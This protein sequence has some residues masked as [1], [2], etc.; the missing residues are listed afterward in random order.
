MFQYFLHENKKLVML[1][2]IWCFFHDWLNF[3][4]FLAN[5]YD[6]FREGLANFLIFFSRLHSNFLIFSHN[7]SPNFMTFSFRSIDK[8]VSF[9]A[10]YTDW[11]TK[12]MLTFSATD[13]WI[14]N[15][16]HV[17]AEEFQDFFSHES[18]T[19]VTIFCP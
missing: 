8:L 7:W 17:I 1:S 14:S 13:W 19:N 10:F 3:M 15:F 5:Q 16:F 6:K 4:F 9:K 2:W 18:L 11:M 12:I